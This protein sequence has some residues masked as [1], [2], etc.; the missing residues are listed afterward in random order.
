VIL[1]SRPP[2][3]LEYKGKS[4][5]SPGKMYNWPIN[6]MVICLAIKQM[7]N[8]NTIDNKTGT[9]QRKAACPNMGR[10]CF[11]KKENKRGKQNSCSAQELPQWE[12]A[13]KSC[14]GQSS[15]PSTH[16]KW[17]PTPCNSALLT[18]ADPCT[19]LRC[20]CSCLY[21]QSFWEPASSWF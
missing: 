18:S 12:S 4:H 3:K 5:T 11:I 19:A 9:T 6:H 1:L 17:L 14:R 15:G 10:L 20:L 13:L 16:I 7:L 2:T 8:L 21:S